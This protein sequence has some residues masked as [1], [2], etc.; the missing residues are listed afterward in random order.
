MS[1]D[2]S[3]R[4]S[5]HIKDGRLDEFTGRQE[6]LKDDITY[7]QARGYEQA[8]MEHYGTKTGKIGKTVSSVNRG[9][10]Y[11]SFRKG[12]IDRRGKAFMAEY[13][14]AKSDISKPPKSGCP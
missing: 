4:L 7:A 6:I 10:K 5:E 8:Y 2:A 12:R 3:R 11:N 1:N 13:K 9:N 14:K